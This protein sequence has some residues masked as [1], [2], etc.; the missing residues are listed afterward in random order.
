MESAEQ[1]RRDFATRWGHVGSSWGVAP[2]T[3][4][5]Q[6]YLLAHGG[7]LTELDLR[8]ALELSHRATLLA[9]RQAHEWGLIEPAGRQRRAGQRGPAG[10]AWVPVTDHWR[11]SHHILSIRRERD[12]QPLGPLLQDCLS[13]LRNLSDDE[14]KDLY[15][16]L[17]DLERFAIV[18]DHALAL[19]QQAGSDATG[20]LVRAF[21]LLDEAEVNRLAQVLLSLSDEELAERLR[22]LAETNK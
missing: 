15:D 6:G 9:L 7:P 18:L 21:S 5:V 13:R 3:A 20:K 11:W 8:Q 22:R 4:A 16:K 1:I 10:R 19:L 2:S 14:A 17:I 12:V